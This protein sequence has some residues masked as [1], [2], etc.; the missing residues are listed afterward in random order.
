MGFFNSLPVPELREWNYPFPFPYPNSQMSFP[1][2]PGQKWSPK[3]GAEN[4]VINFLRTHSTQQ[5][6]LIQPRAGRGGYFVQHEYGVVLIFP[7]YSRYD[8]RL[9]QLLTYHIYLHFNSYFSISAFFM[10]AGLIRESAL[11]F[12]ICISLVLVNHLQFAW[13]GL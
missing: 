8:K 5:E 10:V 13:A 2:T 11:F 7:G 3:R 1:L 9:H 6:R 12:V 4:Y